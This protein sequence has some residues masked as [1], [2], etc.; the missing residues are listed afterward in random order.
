VLW[1][2][3]REALVLVAI[4]SVAGFSLAHLAARVSVAC[5][6]VLARSIRWPTALARRCW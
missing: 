2:I 1:L 3:M 6:T 4:G 5:S